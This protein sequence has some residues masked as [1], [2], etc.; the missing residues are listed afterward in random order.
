MVGAESANSSPP[1]DQP[2]VSELQAQPASKKRKRDGIIESKGAIKKKRSAKAKD[3]E[4]DSFDVENGINTAIGRFD[5]R[6]LA[7]YVAQRT[8]RWAPDL[9]L[10]DL[11]DRQIP[12]NPGSR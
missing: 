3:D 2:H 9:S 6:L 10:V 7:D 1:S 4:V 12:G 5:S 8:K 11:E